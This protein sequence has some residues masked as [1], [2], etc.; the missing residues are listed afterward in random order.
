[1]GWETPGAQAAACDLESKPGLRPR[2]AWSGQGASLSESG[3]AVNRG[4]RVMPQ[5]QQSTQ[6]GEGPSDLFL[7][8]A[9]GGED[10]ATVTFHP[11]PCRGRKAQPAQDPAAGGTVFT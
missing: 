11:D 10:T 1:M 7:L 4:N 9:S 6:H 2:V 8:P 5:A 3:A